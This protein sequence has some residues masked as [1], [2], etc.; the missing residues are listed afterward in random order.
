MQK[1]KADLDSEI[2][3]YERSDPKIISK[4][5]GDGKVAKLAVNRWTDN[6]YLIQQ[7]I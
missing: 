5:E 2:K 1:E 6:L 7:W 3:N 4:M